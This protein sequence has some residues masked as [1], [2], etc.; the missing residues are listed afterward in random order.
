MTDHLVPT[1]AACVAATLSGL[2]DLR[3]LLG[4]EREV[5]LGNDP[6][7]LNAVVSR[8]VEKLTSVETLLRQMDQLLNQAGYDQGI[9]GGNQLLEAHVHPPALAADWQA[10]QPTAQEIAAMNRVNGHLVSQAKADNLAALSTITGRT[11]DQSAYDKRGQ[12]QNKLPGYKLG[13]A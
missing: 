5:V 7:A 6:A 3:S 1:F 11:K 12:G 9:P 2:N 4:Q 8:K 10:L 13:E